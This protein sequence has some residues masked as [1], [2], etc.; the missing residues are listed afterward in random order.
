MLDVIYRFRPVENL[1]GKFKELE[2]RQIYMAPTHEQNDPM[3]GYKNVTFRG[4]EVLWE[5]LLR[6]YVLALVW[7][8]T[9][10]LLQDD[11]EEP[12]IPATLTEDD[13]PTDELRRLYREAS[14]AFLKE[15]GPASLLTIVVRLQEPLRREGVRM[16]LTLLSPA[17]FAAVTAS[18][19][20][21]GLLPAQPIEMPKTPSLHTILEAFTHGTTEIPEAPLESLAFVLNSVSA[22]QALRMLFKLEHDKVGGRS[23]HMH[24]LLWGFP[25]RYIDELIDQLVHPPWG[26]ACF[27]ATCTNAAVWATYGAGHCGVALV[28]RPVTEEGRSFIPLIGVTGSS[29]VLGKPS[30]LIKGTI[31]GQLR[32]ITYTR[33]LPKIEFFQSLGTIPRGKLERAWLSLGNG[34]RSTVVDGILKEDAEW[35]QSYWDSFDRIVTTKLEDWKHE[36]EY[37]IVLPDMLGLRQDDPYVEYEFSS[38]VGIVFGMKTN[39]S[40]KLAIMKEIWRQCQAIN[41]DD[42]SFYRMAFH[43]EKG[44]LVRI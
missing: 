36:E 42:F 33:E 37:R 39:E 40:D 10:I 18:F 20:K 11:F 13:L 4:D 1:L 28:Y 26:A 12:N 23:R 19:H 14:D 8:M 22:E 27:S 32:P 17:A 30:N 16:I 29:T 34:K 5:N 41:R 21:R 24:Y 43:A 2:R 35:R 31:K 25:A 6:H 9:N 44:Q 7:V 15:P 38:L 3:D